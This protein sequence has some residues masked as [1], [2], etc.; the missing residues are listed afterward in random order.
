MQGP[1]GGRGTS[2]EGSLR[3]G[4]SEQGNHLCSHSSPIPVPQSPQ[5]SRPA[6]RERWEGR[7]HVRPAATHLELGVPATGHH[8]VLP[9]PAPRPLASLPVLH[10]LLVFP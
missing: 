7:S 10:L 4:S 3:P 5:P 8:R 1:A 6:Q 9:G 2:E